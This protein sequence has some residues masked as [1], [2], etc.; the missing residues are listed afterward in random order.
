MAFVLTLLT[1]GFSVIQSILIKYWKIILTLVVVLALFLVHVHFVTEYGDAQFKKG[2]AATL[3]K[4]KT[5]VAARNTVNRV[6]EDRADA[7]ITGYAIQKQKL[8]TIRHDAEEK[9]SEKIETVIGTVPMWNS[10]ACSLTPAVIGE[11]NAIRSL[12]PVST[13]TGEVK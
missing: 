4:M 12:G 2:V 10:E 11:R 13:T 8:D 7:G 1:G 6:I 5:Q 3:A 9:S